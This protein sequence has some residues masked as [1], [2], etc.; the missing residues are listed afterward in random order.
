MPAPA[1][2]RGPPRTSLG[3]VPAAAFAASGVA[4]SPRAPLL[5]SAGGDSF[6]HPRASSA[7]SFRT[8]DA[9]A[10]AALLREADWSDGAALPRELADQL[11]IQNYGHDLG[12]PYLSRLWTPE[13][14]RV[15]A[16]MPYSVPGEVFS[17]NDR[18]ERGILLHWAR[19]LQHADFYFCVLLSGLV[20]LAHVAFKEGA[21]GNPDVLF[22]L[23]D[24]VAFTYGA[25]NSVVNRIRMQITYNRVYSARSD[26]YLAEP[27]PPKLPND[28]IIRSIFD[29]TL[30]E[31]LKTHRKLQGDDASAKRPAAAAGSHAKRPRPIGSRGGSGQGQRG[32]GNRSGGGDRFRQGA[33]P[34]H[35]PHS[36]Q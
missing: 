24:V 28:C 36:S 6:R 8:H 1:Q 19:D 34:A 4:G 21:L 16:A 30:N 11:F 35:A 18:R 9:K 26:A 13:F 17:G 10:L 15:S 25:R 3:D 27:E 33:G 7:D 32:F 31:L 23:R 29:D 12:G 20:R 2:T 5:P 22:A 14:R